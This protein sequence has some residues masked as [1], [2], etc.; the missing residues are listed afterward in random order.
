MTRH[1]MEIMVLNF[2]ESPLDSMEQFHYIFFQNQ[3][4]LLQHNHL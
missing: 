2:L 1:S 4:T 3:D